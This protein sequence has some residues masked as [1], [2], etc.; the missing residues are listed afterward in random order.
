MKFD[1]L[2]HH[3]HAIPSHDT[4]PGDQPLAPRLREGFFARLATLIG[5]AFAGREAHREAYLAASADLKDY[6]CRL[7][8]CHDE[9]ERH[10]RFREALW[11]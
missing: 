5:E 1:V 4:V 2:V 8:A 11:P 9:E 3:R 6:E 10:R 7:K